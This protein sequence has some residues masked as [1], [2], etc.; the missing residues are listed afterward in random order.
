LIVTAL[1]GGGP[2]RTLLNDFE[3]LVSHQPN[4]P[5]FATLNSF[6]PQPLLNPT[7]TVSTAPFQKE[8]WNLLRQNAIFAST[9]AVRFLFVII[10]TAPAHPKRQTQ[11]I[12]SGTLI[13]LHRG[14]HFEELHG[15][16]PKM[17]KAFFK[18]HVA[19]W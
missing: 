6:A 17:P 10:E 2:K 13:V 3:L 7:R 9:L 1:S 8:Q 16:W 4:D 15:S 19:A 5:L 14:N 12:T 11:S 18:Y